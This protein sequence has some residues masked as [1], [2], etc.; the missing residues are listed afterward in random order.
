MAALRRS[1]RDATEYKAGLDGLLAGGDGDGQIALPAAEAVSRLGIDISNRSWRD[2]RESKAFLEG[3]GDANSIGVRED[4]TGDDESESKGNADCNS[5][6]APPR[7]RAR[8]S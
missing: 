8:K 3:A 7:R 1:V 5:A 6:V 2:A 4:S